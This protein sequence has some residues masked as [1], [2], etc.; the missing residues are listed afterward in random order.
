MRVQRLEPATIENPDAAFIKALVERTGIHRYCAIAEFDG[1]VTDKGTGFQRLF[2]G[3]Y[4]I[5]RPEEWRIE[6]YA[7]FQKMRTVSSPSYEQ[8][9]SE[10]CSRTKAIEPSFSSKMLAT[11]DVNKPVWDRRVIAAL[12]KFDP[13]LPVAYTDSVN[14]DIKR[15][16]AAYE[17]LNE[18][19]N[20]LL[21]R[22]I[23]KRCIGLFDKLLSEYAGVSHMKKLDVIM[24]CAG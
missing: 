4:N 10:L 14:G 12:K 11:L 15:A 5:R 17:T 7:L 23:G 3:Y 19:C 2:N 8:V 9:I 21:E 20:D 1:D 16:I 6:F 13:K 24:W 22:A 18:V